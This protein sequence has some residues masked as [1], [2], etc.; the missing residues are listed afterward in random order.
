MEAKYEAF[1]AAKEA[2]PK[3]AALRAPRAPVSAPKSCVREA[4]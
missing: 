1:K 2:A 3:E 4:I